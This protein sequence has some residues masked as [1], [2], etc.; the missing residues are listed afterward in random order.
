[1]LWKPL[2]FW[3][4]EA[5]R[6]HVKCQGRIGACRSSQ[7]GGSVKISMMKQMMH[8]EEGTMLDTVIASCDTAARQGVLRQQCNEARRGLPGVAVQTHAPVAV[9][10]KQD[11][12]DGSQRVHGELA[13]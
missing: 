1:M 9:A 8:E 13:H 11:I 12:V 10:S 2:L 4:I 7:L 3:P 6:G 5:N